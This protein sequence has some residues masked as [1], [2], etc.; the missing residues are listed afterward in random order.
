MPKGA[1]ILCGIGLD[2][3]KKGGV[4]MRRLTGLACILGVFCGLVAQGDDERQAFSGRYPH[5]AMFNHDSPGEC[6]VGAVV[7]WQDRLWV[8]TYHQHSPGG[9]TDK[10]WIIDEDLNREH[11]P[12]SVGGTPANRMIH[13]ESGQL[14]IGPYL[15]D[16][17]RNIRVIPMGDG[18]DAPDQKE[19]FGRLTGT[20]RHLHDPG[21]K[22]Y[23]FDMEGLLYEVDVHTLEVD[24]LYARPVPGWH[25]KGAYTAQGR[26]ILANNGEW[27]AGSVDPFR[28]FEYQIDPEPQTDEDA[29][30]LADWDGADDW[31]LVKR[32]QF[33][34][35]TGPGGIHG[36]PDDTA[37]AWATGWDKRSL[38]LMVMD[39]GEWQEFRLPKPDYSYD[40]HHGWHTEWPRIREAVPASDGAP[41][42]LLMNKHGGLFDF[43]QHLSADDTSGLRPIGAYLKVISDVEHWNGGLVFACNETSQFDNPLAGQGQSNLWFSDWDRIQQM[44]QPAGW[45][46]PWMEDPVAAGEPSV[47]F[48]IAGY[49]QRVLHLGHHAGEPV[50]FRLE[51]DA[52]GRGD[53][54]DYA[55]IEA[56]ASGYAY[57]VIPPDTPGEWMRVRADR[58]LD[59]ATAYFHMGPSR[60]ATTDEAL[61]APLANVDDGPAHG[62][63]V[64]RPRG[65]DLG[66]L[67]MLARRVDGDGGVTELGHYEIGPDMV[68]EHR[69]ED[70]DGADY[71]RENA[72]IEP[73]G[74][75]Q[76]PDAGLNVEVDEA[77]VIVTQD[78]QRFRLPKGH[79]AHG[80][81]SPGGDP[82]RIREVVTERSLLNVY[83]TFFMLPRNNSGGVR[84]LKPV[85]T[86]NKR[87]IDFCS[88][89]GMLVIAG[90]AADADPAHPH[91]VASD[92]GETGL[93]FGDIDDL[94]K[95]G[96]P[97][98]VGGPWR[99]AAVKAGEASDPY[100]MTGYDRKRLELSHDGGDDVTFA[101]ET[102]VFGAL[103]APETYFTYK[104]LTVPAGET[105]THEFPEGF[106]AHWIRLR[107][108]A[109]TT[110][111]AT[112]IY[113]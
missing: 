43:P 15:I 65:G 4:F 42:R 108:D 28:P 84:A 13:R 95:L 72:L 107:P 48:L 40:G 8:I 81:A 21:N 46:G 12:G 93:W 27:D 56:S 83:G 82:R 33:T 17:E 100:L 14:L 55:E 70:T 64:I 49:E 58:D 24:L 113:D 105:V 23:H 45:G 30:A 90:A 5:L 106:S 3:H 54:E 98:G 68:L 10:L 109:A 39:G 88:W 74:T 9:S 76:A 112:F 47:P 69:P 87:I 92:D 78:G 11:F 85:A 1:G 50:T 89:R 38:I 99:E 66:T 96:K 60:G 67:H 57:H 101:L 35:V 6:G 63:G 102:D 61:F 91:F 18:P 73:G 7:A 19:L 32:R 29:G 111:T 16:E 31:R 103:H 52:T 22:V 53:W 36:A 80:A 97:R 20:A 51:I 110:A 34:E 104:E 37:P 94:W 75:A 25:A 2:S 44:G 71:L 86:H 62:R 26:L 79:E 77:S 41:A 59:A